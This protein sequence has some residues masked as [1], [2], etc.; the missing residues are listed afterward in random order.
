LV[1]EA[2]SKLRDDDL[3]EAAMEREREMRS[4]L[5]RFAATYRKNGKR[6]KG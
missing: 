1:R 6:K 5:E 2:I 4:E 3:Y